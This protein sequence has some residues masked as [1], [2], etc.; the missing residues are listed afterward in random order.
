MYFNLG[1]VSED[2]LKDSRKSFEN[3]LP[4]SAE[5]AN[6]D[7]TTWGRVPKQQSLVKE[8]DNNVQSRTYQD[9]GLDGMN[10]ADEQRFREPYLETLKTILNPVALAKVEADPSSDNFH[11]FRGSDFDK[12]QVGI[13]GPV[14]K[15]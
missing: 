1:D 12:D 14:Q 9:L 8:F 10:D 6:V 2:I 4:T 11:Y 5:L 13:L 15:L 7:T 3:G